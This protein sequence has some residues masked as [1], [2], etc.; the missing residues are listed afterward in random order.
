MKKKTVFIFV[1]FILVL[2]CNNRPSQHPQEVTANRIIVRFETT[3]SQSAIDSL[4]AELGFEK[5]KD[6]PELNVKV[7]KLPA[8]MKIER[9]IEM[10]QK[11]PHVR[12]AE[13][14]YQVRAL[15]DNDQK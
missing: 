5:I 4:T 6:I 14:D 15:Q 3:A 12:Y 13:P 8:G 9:A 10:C 7:Y 2:G 11:N 1:L